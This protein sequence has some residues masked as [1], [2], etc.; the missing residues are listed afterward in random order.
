MTEVKRFVGINWAVVFAFIPVCAPAQ[1]ALT[2]RSFAVEGSTSGIVI[3]EVN[4]GR[5]W[6][7]GPFEN[8]QLQRLAFRRLGA[9]DDGKVAPEMNLEPGSTLLAQS[10]FTP[11]V[12]LLE[13]GEYALSGFRLKVASSASDVRVA[14]VDSEKLIVDGQPEG[15]SFSVAS[16]EIVYVGHFTVDCNGEPT[17]WRFYIDGQRE[18]DSFVENFRQKYPY[19]KNADVTYRLFETKYFGTPYVLPH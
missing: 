17:L 12:F 4:W 11:Y 8:A 1:E 3:L 16:G 5:H 2:E 9:A 18:F 6:K 10:K 19:V 14:N 15:G 13:P 7:C